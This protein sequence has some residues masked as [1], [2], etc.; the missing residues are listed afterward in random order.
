MIAN[1]AYMAPENIYFGSK[2]FSEELDKGKAD[3]F[4]VISVNI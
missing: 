2:D 4:S 1:P 3:V